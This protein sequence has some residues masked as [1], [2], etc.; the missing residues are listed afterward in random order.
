MKF[1]YDLGQVSAQEPFQKLINQGMIQGQSCFVYRIKGTQQFVS[2][3]LR[4]QY[5]TAPMHVSIDLVKNGVLDTEAFRQWRPELQEAT[6]ILEDGQYRCGTEVEKMSKS[7]HNVVNPDTII[8]QY[9]AD[10]LRLYTLFLGPLEQSKPW[11]THGIEGVSRFLHKLW[12]LFHPAEGLSTEA[13][14]AAALKVLHQTIKKVEDAISRYALNTAV[15]A[16]MVCVN[17]LTALS[18]RH[19]AVLQDLAV[20]LAPFAPHIAEA[21]WQ[22]LGHETSVAY[23]AWPALDTQYLQED[24]FEY[25]ISINGKVRTRLTFG[26]DVPQE[27]MEQ[28]VLA[29][30]NVQKWIQGKSLKKIIIVPQRI[31]NVVV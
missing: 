22:H 20:L 3:G 10:T 9:G 28:Q 24:T 5:D 17:E 29:D 13:P 14:P 26:L 12:K 19:R 11:D 6:F 7:K 23:A 8:E 21:L 2:H 4:E 31:V 15:S 25:P 16:F 1:L 18:C 30:A 27:T